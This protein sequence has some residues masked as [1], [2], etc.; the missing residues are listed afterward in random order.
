[1]IVKKTRDKREAITEMLLDCIE[2]CREGGRNHPRKAFE[3]LVNFM[4]ARLGVNPEGCELSQGSVNQLDA[5]LNMGKFA[6]VTDDHLGHIFTELGIG[7]NALGQNFTPTNIADFMVAMTCTDL[8]TG[9]KILD[10]AAGTGV[11]LISAL[12]V[13]SPGV[14]LY[15]VEIDRTSYRAALVQLTVFTSHGKRN[16]F[17]LL[18]GDALKMVEKTD[19][20]RANVWNV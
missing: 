4:G 11:F 13:V 6:E 17:F 3:E 5:K 7:N 8:K 2:I 18:N 12:K 20:S 10:P 19:W 14:E 15:G 1:V 16:P 9:Q